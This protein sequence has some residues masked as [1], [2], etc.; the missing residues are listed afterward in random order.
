MK[1]VERAVVSS[2]R[3]GVIGNSHTEEGAVAGATREALFQ[4]MPKAIGLN[5]G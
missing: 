2:K 5:V 3:E 4:I 1:I